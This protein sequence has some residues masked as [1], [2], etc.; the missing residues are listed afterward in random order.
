[1]K[2][3]VGQDD[4]QASGLLDRPKAPSRCDRWRPADAVAH[5]AGEDGEMGKW[6]NS[7]VSTAAA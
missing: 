6:L 1:M 3:F 2:R 5:L 4:P 7:G